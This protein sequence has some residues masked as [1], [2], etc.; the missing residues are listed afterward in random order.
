LYYDYSTNRIGIG[1]VTPGAGKLAI[2][3]TN[4]LVDDN[5]IL[6]ALP[7]TAG[8]TH[9]YASIHF[10]TRGG[11][12][13]MM[14]E[15][16]PQLQNLENWIIKSNGYWDIHSTTTTGAIDIGNIALSVGVVTNSLLRV[17]PTGIGV[18]VNPFGLAAVDFQ[19]Q[20]DSDA[21]LIYA[22][23]SVDKVGIG[24]AAPD[25]K[26][27]IT[28][29]LKVD[30]RIYGDS[31]AATAAN[32]LTLVNANLAIVAGA[33]QINAIT[34][35]GWTAGSQ[36]TILFSG[37]PLV[38]HNTAG[39]AGTAKLFLAG[40]ADFQAAANSVLTLIWDGTQWQEVSRKVA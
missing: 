38:K 27:H 4:A 8:G 13:T 26:L 35:T 16:D 11:S 25:E 30:G 12:D 20:G 40:S 3:L 17:L 31:D 19:V 10:K 2:T 37:A 15:T 34:T 5:L 9:N 23:A 7:T 29:N 36:I 1:T 28:G 24:N 18:I 6:S 22:D 39:G 32:D 14:I 33:T 21:N